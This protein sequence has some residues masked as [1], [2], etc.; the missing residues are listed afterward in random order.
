MAF[1]RAMLAFGASANP[2][3]A[4][5]I[6]RSRTSRLFFETPAHIAARLKNE[7]LVDL[8]ASSGADMSAKNDDDVTVSALVEAWESA[9]E[10]GLVEELRQ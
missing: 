3:A 4:S 2:K 8:L 6:R 7:V 5:A 9:E 10:K 1:V